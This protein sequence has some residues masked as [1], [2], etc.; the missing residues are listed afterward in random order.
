MSDGY[1]IS[2]EVMG[3]TFG[4]AY[5]PSDIEL[6]QAFDLE[7]DG[8]T[9]WQVNEQEEF[10]LAR[11]KREHVDKAMKRRE[12][13]VQELAAFYAANECNELSPFEDS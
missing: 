4:L 3:N 9:V 2:R 1:S 13:R 10:T 7:I 11:H 5:S 12:N 8:H 6:F